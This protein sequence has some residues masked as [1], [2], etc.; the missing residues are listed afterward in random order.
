MLSVASPLSLAALVEGLTLK[1]E[2]VVNVGG[3]CGYLSLQD[4][5]ILT[6]HPF[7]MQ[8]QPGATTPSRKSKR[9]VRTGAAD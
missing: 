9:D 5:L 3:R 2:T 4:F 1:L 8:L 6:T 7:L